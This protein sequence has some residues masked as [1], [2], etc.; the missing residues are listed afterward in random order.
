MK[1]IILDM[2][3]VLLDYNP[4][5]ILNKVCETEEEK[6]I[7]QRQLFEGPEWIQGDLGHITNTERFV[8]VSKRVPEKMHGK[9]KECVENWDICMTPVRGA[10]EFCKWAKE[11]G[12]QLY[13][14]SNACTKFYEYFP[15]Y[16]DLDFFEGVVVSSDI[17]IIKPDAQIYQYLLKKYNLQPQECL[18]VDDRKENVEAACSLQMKGIVFQNNYPE[19]QSYLAT[20]A[21]E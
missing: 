6:E 11:A 8:G 4:D 13:V 20:S 18:F 1:N 9:L 3:N 15:K 16:Y 10:Q 5:I 19:I 14:L 17:H 21:A 7:I 2:G 12:Y